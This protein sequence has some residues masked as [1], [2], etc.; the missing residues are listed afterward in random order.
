MLPSSVELDADAVARAAVVLGS[1]V[2]DDGADRNAAALWRGSLAAPR[3]FY[4]YAM[5]LDCLAHA[6]CGCAALERCIGLS[7]SEST[8]CAPHCESDVYVTCG[9]DFDLPDT[10]DYRLDCGRFGMTCDPDAICSDG[11]ALACDTSTSYTCTGDDRQQACEDGFLQR[12]PACGTVGLT[13][14]DGF[15]TGAGAACINV[16]PPS[17]GQGAISYE[18]VGCSGSSLEACANGHATTIDCSARGPGFSCQEFDDQFF[19]G[20]ASE[21]VPAPV[22]QRSPSHPPSCDGSVLTFCNAGRLEHV[23]CTSL[24]FTG[25]EIAPSAGRYGCTPSLTDE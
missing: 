19:C 20:L 15:C 25:C 23:D 2:P 1:C 13:C 6:Q 11:P 22:G 16:D 4:R 24:G 5:Q 17:F 7:L 3:I 18:G 8:A 12:S 9:G 21:C 10:Y 14:A